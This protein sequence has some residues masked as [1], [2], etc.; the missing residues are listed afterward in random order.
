MGKKSFSGAARTLP[1]VEF[2]PIWSNAFEQTQS[3]AIANSPEGG[4]GRRYLPSDAWGILLPPPSCKEANRPV[5]M[6][7][8]LYAHQHNTSAPRIPTPAPR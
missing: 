4:R 6:R 8:F 1:S 5:S 2:A 7:S 3:G